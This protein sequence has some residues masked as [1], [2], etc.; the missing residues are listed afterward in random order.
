MI[1][2]VLARV[3]TQGRDL[4]LKPLYHGV[5]APTPVASAHSAALRCARGSTTGTRKATAPAGSRLTKEGL[6]P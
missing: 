2:P 6:Q 4:A 5:P 3:T 1:T